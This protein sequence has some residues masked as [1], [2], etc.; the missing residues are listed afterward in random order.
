ML[1][2][3]SA[4]AATPVLGAPRA[5]QKRR[6]GSSGPAIPDARSSALNFLPQGSP[7]TRHPR[8]VAEMVLVASAAAILPLADVFALTPRATMRN[9]DQ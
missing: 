6:P 8:L 4:I 1:D 9:A 5:K 3:L 2:L 7:A